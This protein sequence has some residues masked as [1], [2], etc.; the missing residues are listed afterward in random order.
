MGERSRGLGAAV[1][2]SAAPAAVWGAHWSGLGAGTWAGF[3]LATAAGAALG[4]W[5]WPLFTGERVAGWPFAVLFG[6]T[7]GLVS[8]A[9][10][11]GPVGG[12]FATVA[13]GV[14]GLGAYGVFALRPEGAHRS[15]TALAWLLGS[16][17]AAVV[18]WGMTQ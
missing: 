5:L 6:A 8:G 1:G 14:S 9:F 3:L 7:A 11:G 2:A 10:A 4:A 12:V 17:L 13:G 18:A 15:T 16:C